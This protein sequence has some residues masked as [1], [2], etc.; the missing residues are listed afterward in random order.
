[1]R[2][3]RM[4]APVAATLAVGMLA[5]A[6]GGGGGV[7]EQT[8]TLED[9]ITIQWGEPQNKLIPTNN[10]D[11]N[12]GMVLDALFT[13]LV[14]Y[15]PKTFE[16]YNAMAKSITA[17]P[18]KKTYTIK[19]KKGWTFHNGEEVTADNFVKAWNYA[20]YA[21]NAQSMA[22]FFQKIQGY[23]AV[24]PSD[25]DGDGPKKAPEP[26]AKKLSGLKIVD[27]HTFKVTL[28]QPFTIF[29]KTIGYAAYSPLPDMF[30]DNPDKFASAP[31]GNGPYKF[32][33]WVPKQ[34]LTVSKYGKYKGEDKG[35]VKA[36]KYVV[37]QKPQTAYQDLK[38]GSLDIMYAI[39]DSA[40]AG[41]RWKQ[42]LGKRAISREELGITVL[43]FPMYDERFKNPKIRQAFSMAVDRES[44]VKNV[45]NGT[46]SAAHGWA[47][48]SLPHYKQ[49]QCNTFC[50]Y[51][52]QKAKQ[53][54]KE[55]GGFKGT[56]ELSF[57]ADGGHAGWVKAVAGSIRKTL[58]IKVTTNP[59]PSFNT[60]LDKLD[61]KKMPG[62]FRYG[63]VADYPNVESFLGPIY[64]S[65]GSSNNT[66]YSNEKFD[67]LL[68]KGNTAPTVKQANEYYMQAE[69][70]LANTMPS[71]PIFVD[72]VSGARSER[73]SKVQLTPRQTPALTTVRIANQ[74]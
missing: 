71:I 39:P 5:S 42:E 45:F 72:Q 27:D 6:C 55:A 25:P 14:E 59:V 61:Q 56:L 50:S 62:P 11:V 40:F 33:K 18:D 73:V 43:G 51:N 31:V 70:V 34:Y 4:V 29:P 28:N 21:P 69:K 17:S 16:P 54:L 57:N 68:Q 47:P 58:G 53:L 38:S 64:A 9:P 52:P 74:G 63:W 30:F 49:E 7:T 41:N 26:S 35:K 3:R 65:N 1:M 19:I 48:A 44:I 8:G 60:Y 67:S 37:Y 22:Y 32:E 2:K 66:F 20:A 12:G 24:H 36:F 10:S 13:G 46:A 15:N 23:K